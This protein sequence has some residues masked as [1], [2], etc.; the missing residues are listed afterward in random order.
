MLIL[1]FRGS[2]SALTFRLVYIPYNPFSI[3]T[4]IF[5]APSEHP[6]NIYD[7]SPMNQPWMGWTV[8]SPGFQASLNIRNP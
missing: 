5:R 2:N 8:L 1:T 4:H 7:K 3:K 6:T